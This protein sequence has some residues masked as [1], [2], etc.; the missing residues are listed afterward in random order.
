[1][2]EIKTVLVVGAGVMGHGFAQ[3]F[4]LNSID[5]LLVDQN[6]ELLDRAGIWIR[7]NLEFMVELNLIQPPE[8]EKA[9]GKITRT[10]DLTG[11]VAKADYVLE[12][13]TEN[14]ELKQDLFK[15]LGEATG[16]EVILATN[17]SSY[18]I[19]E[20]ARVT[21]Y[22][23]RVLGTHWFH[24][25]PITPAVEIIPADTTDQETIDRAVALMERIGKF[26]TMCKSAPGFV[27]NR[28]QFAM[29]AEALAIVQEGLASPVE[30]DRIVKSSFGFRLSAFGPF[31]IMD[32]A[33]IDTY[34]AI[35]EYLY[36]KL[37]REQFKPPRILSDLIEKGRLGLK[38]EKGFY[39]HEDGAA[40]AL[41]QKRD[42]RLYAR[43]EIFR[44]E[45]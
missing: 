32:Q 3:T 17:T 22:P 8:I 43:R 1:M 31:E 38:N 2:Q 37:G 9:L 39:D 11:S 25:P 41:K 19:N 21:R 33:G 16:P 4:A 7:E 44:K 13:I 27:A 6:E 18:D 10:K 34:R 14:L 20:L 26:P 24:P 12:A 15:L 36:D 40:E 42:R 29:A 23:Q 45:N 30:V 35:F 5:V 28:I